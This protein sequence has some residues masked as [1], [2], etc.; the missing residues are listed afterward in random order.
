M[1]KTGFC[2][3]QVNLNSLET[4]LEGDIMQCRQDTELGEFEL[5]EIT[6]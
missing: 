5:S 6:I 1:F 3:I 2:K 4:E